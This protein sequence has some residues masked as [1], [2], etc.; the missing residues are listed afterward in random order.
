[1]LIRA[2]ADRDAISSHL[3]RYR[4]GR[5]DDW[6]DIIDMLT[7]PIRE[8]DGDRP[9]LIRPPDLRPTPSSSVSAFGLGCPYGLG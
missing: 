6:A 1:M 3:R 2:Q 9:V 4:G 5:G 8:G 7:R